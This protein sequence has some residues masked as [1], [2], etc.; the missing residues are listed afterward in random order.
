MNRI[1]GG[2][3]KGISFCYGIS[4]SDIVLTGHR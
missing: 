1:L 3:E 2:S 4:L